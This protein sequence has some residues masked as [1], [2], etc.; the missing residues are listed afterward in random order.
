M[1]PREIYPSHPVTSESLIP[2]EKVI[3]CQEEAGIHHLLNMGTE[4]LTI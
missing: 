1:V 4:G 2:E 3:L